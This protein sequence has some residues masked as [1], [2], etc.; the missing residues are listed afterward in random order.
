MDLDLRQDKNLQAE[1]VHV[2]MDM[3]PDVSIQRAATNNIEAA[4]LL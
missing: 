3:R 2:Y 4:L 1:A